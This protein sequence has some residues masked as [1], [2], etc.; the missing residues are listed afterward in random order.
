MNRHRL[1]IDV[2][3]VHPAS[4]IRR[5]RGDDAVRSNRLGNRPSGTQVFRQFCQGLPGGHFIN[6]ENRNA[7]WFEMAETFNGIDYR[8]YPNS[9]LDYYVQEISLP[10]KTGFTVNSKFQ[11]VAPLP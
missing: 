10:N 11:T 7:V 9:T 1:G 5:R 3:L 6:I 8:N 2:R 4:E